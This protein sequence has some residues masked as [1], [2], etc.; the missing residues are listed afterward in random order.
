MD[1]I[2][3]SQVGL[4]N[5]LCDGLMDQPASGLYQLVWVD[6]PTCRDVAL[7]SIFKSNRNLTSACIVKPIENSFYHT[8][9]LRLNLIIN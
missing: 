5:I 3:T 7:V 6:T 1:P 8:L 9:F 4:Y 2:V